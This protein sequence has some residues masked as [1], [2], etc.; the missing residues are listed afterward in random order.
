MAALTSTGF[1]LKTQN[2]YFDDEV[3]LYTDIDPKWNLDPSTPDGL[4]IAHDAEIFGNL[5]EVLLA[6]YNSK[7]PNKARDVELD[8]VSALTGTYRSQGTPSTATITLTGTAGIVVPSGT[9]FESVVDGSQWTLD[10]AAIIGGGGTVD[11]AITCTANGATE[12]GIGDISRIVDTIGGLQS[13]SNAGVAVIG[14][15][16]ETNAELRL[17]RLLSV[18]RS[19]DNQIDSMLGEIGATAGVRRFV[20]YENDTG[21]VDANGLPAHSIAPIIDG[22]TDADVALA[23][24]LKKNPGVAL[25]AAGTPVVVT[26][27]SP[28]YPAST[29]DITFGRPD[30]IDITVAVNVTDDGSLPSNADELIKQAIID[31]SGGD[32]VDATY[33]FNPLGF[34]IGE[35]VSISRMYTPVNNVIGQYGNSYVTSITLNGG[36]SNIAIAFDELSRW[37]S[38]NITVNII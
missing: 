32:L 37:T 29:K 17:R 35:D 12:A 16:Q 13:A 26:V 38:A 4:K 25:Y 34:D 19:G 8:I 1:S 10:A 9:V 11:A 20:I 21:S 18:G 30:Y 7:D 36:S 15:N 27:T 14:T 3:T 6:A 2:E 28:K 22:G 24:Y 33:G 31:Y 23:I 5:D